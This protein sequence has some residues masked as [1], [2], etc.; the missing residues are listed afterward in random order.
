MQYHF[1]ICGKEM[2]LICK[3]AMQGFDVQVS[4]FLW[5]PGFQAPSDFPPKTLILANKPIRDESNYLSISS[6]FILLHCMCPTNE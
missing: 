4:E 1:L 2:N 5:L 6:Y 3:F